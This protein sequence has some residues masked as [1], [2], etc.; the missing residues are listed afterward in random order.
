MMSAYTGRPAEHVINRSDQIGSAGRVDF[1]WCA[2]AIIAGNRGSEADNRGMN[3]RRIAHAGPSR[4]PGE[5]R[6]AAVARFLGDRMKKQDRDCRR[7]TQ[8]LPTPASTPLTNK[9]LSRARRQ[10]M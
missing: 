5:R 6:R 2:F 9:S 4:G 10:R 8:Q 1:E 3:A 7:N